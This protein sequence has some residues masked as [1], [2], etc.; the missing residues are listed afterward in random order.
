MILV[1][2]GS[3][4]FPFDRLLQ[5]AAELPRTERVVIQHGPSD[6][7]PAGASCTDFV[8][9]EELA[10]LIREAR[11]VV[12]HAGVGS[13][14]LAL[15]N[16][17]KPI[18]LPRL[19]VFGEAVDD[20]QLESAR[21]L[22]RAG[23]VTLVEEPKQLATAIARARSHTLGASLS[24]SDVPLPLVK[25]LRDYLVKLIGPPAAAVAP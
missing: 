8:P 12:T 16:G 17:K 3:S 5:A 6:V 25:E 14:L 11:V 2:V 22:A 24:S 20:H 1:A 19:R 7:R 9:F 21:R 10:N 4:Q 18:V 23:V 15:A 13:I